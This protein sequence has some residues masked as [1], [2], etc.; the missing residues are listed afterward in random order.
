MMTENL[1]TIASGTREQLGSI[2]DNKGQKLT[3]NDTYICSS[4]PKDVTNNCI[5]NGQLVT[6][7][8][9]NTKLDAAFSG[10][11]SSSIINTTLAHGNDAASILNMY[12][13]SR[14]KYKFPPLTFPV[15]GV[16]S[17]MDVLYKT[18]AAQIVRKQGSQVNS[19]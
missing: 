15:E 12:T 3:A 9:K 6:T 19:K 13:L 14:D 7:Q 2:A 16:E 17:V 4:T 5:Q 8:T 11:M 18:Q 1:L 10:A